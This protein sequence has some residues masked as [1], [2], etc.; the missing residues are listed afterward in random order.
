MTD[1]VKTN[2][3]NQGFWKGVIVGIT[4]GF[5]FGGCLGYEIGTR[6]MQD[7]LSQRNEYTQ[8][9]FLVQRFWYS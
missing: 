4:V 2:V 7:Q 3:F 8:V 6:Q 5:A 9:T 1:T